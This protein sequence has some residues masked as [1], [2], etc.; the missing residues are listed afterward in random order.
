M[1]IIVFCCVLLYTTDTRAIFGSPSFRYSI[2]FMFFNQSYIEYLRLPWL[3]RYLIMVSKHIS[4]R[5]SSEPH[6]PELVLDV[7]C[8]QSCGKAAYSSARE[9]FITLRPSK[10]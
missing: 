1:K 2:W 9:I 7:W 8:F 3:S 5:P 4:L 10:K 6:S